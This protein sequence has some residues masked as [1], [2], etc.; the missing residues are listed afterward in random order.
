MKYALQ[1]QPSTQDVV[2]LPPLSFHKSLFLLTPEE[3]S[4]GVETHTGLRSALEPE[5]HNFSFHC[6]MV[7]GVWLLGLRFPCDLCD[8]CVVRLVRLTWT[9][10]TSGSLPC[11]RCS[12]EALLE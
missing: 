10:V 5:R 1:P 7:V 11:G 9:W 6:A 2:V 8:L 12:T 3:A 4:D